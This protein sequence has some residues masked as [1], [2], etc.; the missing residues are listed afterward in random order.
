[1]ARDGQFPIHGQSRKPE[2]DSVDEG[3][4][5][6]CEQKRQ[7]PGLEFPDGD[8]LVQVRDNASAAYHATFQ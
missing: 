8:G 4:N 1:L 5:K 3:D 6:E 2:V 7:K